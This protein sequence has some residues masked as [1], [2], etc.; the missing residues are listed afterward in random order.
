[1]LLMLIST[2]STLDA[3][4]AD[5]IP[6]GSGYMLLS[7]IWIDPSK[8]TVLVGDVAFHI[9]EC[10][11]ALAGDCVGAC[12]WQRPSAATNRKRRTSEARRRLVI[13]ITPVSE[14]RKMG[15]R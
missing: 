13:G 1:M 5:S 8:Y 14:K 2:A 15:V 7:P 6:C 11:A 10:R 3:A 4:N 9:M 12:A